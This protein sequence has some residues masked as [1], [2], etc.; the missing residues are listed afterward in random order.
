[1]RSLF[2]RYLELGSVQALAQD[3]ERRGIRTKQRTLANGR[4]I[5]GGAFGV[6]ALAHVLRNRFYIGEVVYRGDTFRGD[7]EPILD[8]ALFAAVQEKL[9]AQAVERRRR[10]RGTAALL[11]GRLFDAHGH[12]LTPTHT[13]KNGVRYLYYVSQ[14]A[15][16]KQPSAPVARVPAGELEAL[17]V[18]A[19]RRHLQRHGTASNPIPEPDHDLIEQHLRRVTLSATEVTLH[20]RRNAVG[21]NPAASQGEPLLAGAD[22]TADTI[23]LPWTVSAAAPVKGIVHAPAHNTPMKP[24]RREM[25][26][27]AI[28]KA[29][30]WIKDIERGRSFA[31]IARREGKAERYIR[32]LAPLAFVSPRIVTAIIDGTAPPRLTATALASRLPY[33][34]AEQERRIR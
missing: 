3:L 11:T 26:L 23:A 21:N 19:I 25:L 16:R 6:G 12:R 4:I 32:H 14:T 31:E 22:N 20:L 17:V 9:S 13:N 28:A 18:D 5:G 10:I 30:K 24:G 15:L 29:R 7:H 33:S 2:A 34:W 1:V 8:P 27:T